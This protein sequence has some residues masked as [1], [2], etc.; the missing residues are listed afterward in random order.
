[1]NLIDVPS[2]SSSSVV[3]SANHRNLGDVV[4]DATKDRH[5]DATKDGHRNT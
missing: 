4:D 2:L 1:M 3:T 5:S